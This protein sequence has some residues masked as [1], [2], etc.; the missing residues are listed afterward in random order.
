[1]EE[2]LLAAECLL[3]GEYSQVEVF[4]PVV[5]Y[6]PVEASRQV[7][8]YLLAVASQPVGVSSQAAEFKP[9]EALSEEAEWLRAISQAPLRLTAIIPFSDRT[10]PLEEARSSG[11]DNHSSWQNRR[12]NC[13]ITFQ[14]GP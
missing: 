10:I 4:Q 13:R 6:S 9:E 3:A 2:Y 14:W 1:M 8:E 11:L 12:A 7:E 5:E